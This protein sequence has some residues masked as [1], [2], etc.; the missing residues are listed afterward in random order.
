MANDTLVERPGQFV[1]ER[2]IERRA[3][4]DV[5]YETFLEEYAAEGRPV[6]FEDSVPHWR[7]LRTW[8]PDFFATNFADCDVHV[9]DGVSMR[10][11][12][13]IDAV[14]RSTPQSPGPYLHKLIIEREI[15][16]LLPDVTP[17]NRFGFPGRLASPIMPKP[18][19]RPDG[20]LKL[21]FG[22]PGARFPYPHYDGDNAYAV[23]TGI[24][25]SKEFL[26]FAP[27]DSAHMYP[28]PNSANVSL[29]EDVSRVDLSRY[30]RFAQAVPYRGA[31]GP[32]D[33]IFI[34]CRWWHAA[35][36]P[37]L[38]ISVCTNMITAVN[39]RGFVN[40]VCRPQAGRSPARQFVKRM[41]L[42]GV[43]AVLSGAEGVQRSAPRSAGARLLKRLAPRYG[44][45]A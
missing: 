5:S 9:T 7:A 18:W 38:S 28:K 42:N 14:R 36:V 20:Y 15:P 24:Y 11:G 39:W 13:F 1:R 17:G 30:P 6:I 35:Q 2:A 29:L 12:D 3:A 34:P 4:S 25:G 16:A 37:E 32:G 8:T 21:L 31:I 45:L 23:I 26:L 27:E 43:G 19:N 22:G 10:F 40:E 41:L 44:D 33:A